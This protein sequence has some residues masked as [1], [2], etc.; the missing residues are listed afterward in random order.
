[1]PADAD[2]LADAGVAADKSPFSDVHAAVDRSSG[3]NMTM[4][5]D[6]DVVLHQRH[7]VEYAVAA[8]RRCGVD[9]R[10]MHDDRAVSDHRVARN[11]CARRNDRGQSESARQRELKQTDSR[12]RRLDLTN[13]DQR[14][15]VLRLQQCEV[16]VCPQYSVA[17]HA[18]ANLFGQPYQAPDSE[19]ALLLDD[20]EASPG[21]AA[22]TQQ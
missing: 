12:T 17:Q 11:V 21:V 7:A 13:G 14:V 10:S 18:R 6:H 16:R 20:I 9:D 8:H 5:G 1:M 3:G 19:N 4:I 22:G 15:R 2:S